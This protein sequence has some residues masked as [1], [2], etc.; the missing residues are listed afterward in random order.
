M[1]ADIHFLMFITAVIISGTIR[2]LDT[3]TVQGAR[4]HVTYS[5][6]DVDA[7]NLVSGRS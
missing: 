2:S 5:G 4:I 7:L 1:A 3:F 6:E